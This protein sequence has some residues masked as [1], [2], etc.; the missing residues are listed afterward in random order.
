[1]W[2][3]LFCS[4]DGSCKPWKAELCWVR[5]LAKIVPCFLQKHVLYFSISW[6]SLRCLHPRWKEVSTL[7]GTFTNIATATRYACRHRLHTSTTKQQTQNCKS[8]NTKWKYI[9]EIT[10]LQKIPTTQWVSQPTL[11]PEQNPPDTWRWVHTLFTHPHTLLHTQSVS[12][13]GHFLGYPMSV[14]FTVKTKRLLSPFSVQKSQT[15]T[16]SQHR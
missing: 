7:P 4:Y 12:V 3:D 9:R 13:D 8:K 1:M 15:L 11:L 14:R 6:L 10:E 2:V 16:R 5:V